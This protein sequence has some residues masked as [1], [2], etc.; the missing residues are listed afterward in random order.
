[1]TTYAAALGR[2]EQIVLGTSIVQTWPRHPIAIAQQA[3]ALAQLAPGRFR[4]GI[5]PAHEPA[6]VRT[7]GVEW[8][9]PLTQLREY[10][11]VVRALLTEGTTD[12][13][14]THVT[15]RTR[16]PAPSQP[17]P[18]LASA[19]QPASFELCGELTDGALS[20]MCPQHYLVTEALP[21]IQRGAERAGRT[22]PPLV[23]HVP[24]AVSDDRE[25]VR[26]LARERLGNYASVPFYRAMFAR[27]G[28][29]DAG[30]GYS[31]ELLDGLVVSGSESEVA[32]RLAAMVRDDGFG[33]V[34]A[35]PVIDPQDREGSLSRAFAAVA[36][37]GRAL[38]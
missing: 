16:L 34:L 6:M 22:P 31:D 4:L 25:A 35:M 19:L 21:A 27:A 38:G 13:E 29:P 8:R 11:T 30:D 10:I 1:M 36:A 3:L 15:A 32:D 9:K 33:E 24:V 28:F 37:A 17:V 2:T 26:T 18:L 5:G 7:Y 23:A 14:G 20:W 12:F